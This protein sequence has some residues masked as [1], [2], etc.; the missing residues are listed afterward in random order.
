MRVCTADS[1][2]IWTKDAKARFELQIRTVPNDFAKCE[3][4]KMSGY[5]HVP[6]HARSNI[7]SKMH[8]DLHV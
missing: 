1:G 2:G 4:N 5:T 6:S 8:N 3:D 7:Q